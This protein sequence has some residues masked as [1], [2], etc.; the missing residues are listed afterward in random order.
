MD[1]RIRELLGEGTDAAALEGLDAYLSEHY[2]AKSEIRALADEN[3]RLRGDMERLRK[4]EAVKE[5]LRRLGVADPD[6]VI[7]RKNGVDGFLFDDAGKPADLET[8]VSELASTAAAAAIF[9]DRQTYAPAGGNSAT[10]NPFSA[11]SFNLT[12]QGRLWKESPET[13]R[14]LAAAAG[15]K[16]T[17]GRR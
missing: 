2:T 6:Y 4:T 12:K 10:D 17:I 9:P 11:D 3:S 14:R 15:I 8:V 16:L 1:E 5:G 7:Y 13:A